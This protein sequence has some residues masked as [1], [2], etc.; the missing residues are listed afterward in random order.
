MFQPDRPASVPGYLPLRMAA[1]WASAVRDRTL[2]FRYDSASGWLTLQDPATGDGIPTFTPVLASRPI[3][4]EVEVAVAGSGEDP[5]SGTW[6]TDG[7]SAL[8]WSESAVEK[9]LLPYLASVTAN[10]AAPFLAR[11][12]RAWYEYP[13]DAVQVIAIARRLGPEPAA[14]GT[15]LTPEATLGLVILRA[16]GTTLDLVSLADFER[17][18]GTGTRGPDARSAATDPEVCGGW[19]VG[20]TLDSLVVRDVAEFVSGLRGNVVS[21]VREGSQLIPE[22]LPEGSATPVEGALFTADAR[23]IRPDRPAPSRV[24]LRVEPA[25]GIETRWIPL[26][27]VLDGAGRD[28]VPDSAFWTDSAVE[29]LLLPYYASVKER[30]AWRFLAVLMAKWEGLVSPDAYGRAALDTAVS[31]LEEVQPGPMDPSPV[32]ATIHLPRSEYA[33]DADTRAVLLALRPDGTAT[34][35]P[36]WHDHSGEEGLAAKRSRKTASR[37]R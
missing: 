34:A 9:F 21:F 12:F 20:E 32:F 8:L 4:T 35:H 5:V 14:H 10:R 33:E 27:P 25:P 31:E 17:E 29:S 28:R 24:A 16:G 6:S 3:V 19:R 36:V 2:S 15:A 26:V 11:V 22:L 13:G 18:Y 23:R 1:E 37:A 30:Q 7:I